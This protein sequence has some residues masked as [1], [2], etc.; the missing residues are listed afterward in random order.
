MGL[1]F[2][3]IVLDAAVLGSHGLLFAALLTEQA[4]QHDFELNRMDT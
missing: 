2:Y 4:E 3:D 1:L